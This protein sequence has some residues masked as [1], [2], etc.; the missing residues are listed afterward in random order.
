[1]VRYFVFL[2]CWIAFATSAQDLAFS[3]VKKLP[4]SINS[5]AEEVSPLVSPDGK[6]LYFVRVLCSDN[7][8][9]RYSGADVWVSHYDSIKSDW[10]KPSNTIDVFNDKAHNAVVGISDHSDVIYQLKASATKKVHGIYFSTHKNKSWTPPELIPIP[11]LTTE[12]F[13]GVYVS[14]DLEVI[15]MSMKDADSKGQEDLYVSLKN[16]EGEWSKPLNLGS[17]INTAGFEISPFLTADKKRLYFASNGHPGLGDADIFYSDR[18]GDSWESWSVPVNLG[19]KVNSKRFDA[20]FSIRDSIAYFCSNRDGQFSDLYKA[21]KQVVIDSTQLRVKKIVAEAQTLL[22]DLG[23]DGDDSSVTTLDSIFVHFDFNS[24]EMNRASVGQ[25]NK[26]IDLIKKRPS[27]T[28]TL[29]AYSTYSNEFNADSQ[30]DDLWYKRLE[31]IKT[32]LQN[33]SVPNLNINY[34]L[35][36]HDRKERADKDGLV[37]VR[38]Q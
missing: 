15:L 9:G 3:T 6:S 33:A 12:E 2:F 29:V 30:N 37:L 14:P 18:L 26:M 35:K 1:M 36:K 13:L 19:N 17:R 27:N 31:V 4:A 38:C 8:G 7:V 21:S 23:D 5:N 34:E 28:L 16:A 24:S 10:G 32:F 25:L 20:Y 11:F 22:A